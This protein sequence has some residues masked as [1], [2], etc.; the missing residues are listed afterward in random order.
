MCYL[1]HTY[2]ALLLTLQQLSSSTFKIYFSVIFV[3]KHIYFNAVYQISTL[4]YRR[5][6]NRS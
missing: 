4:V 1:E 5:N 2:V 3:S 6:S